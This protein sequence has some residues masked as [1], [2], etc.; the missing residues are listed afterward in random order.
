MLDRV[1]NKGQDL[2]SL[3][4]VCESQLAYGA[5]EENR[6]V[7]GKGAWHTEMGHHLA[8][9]LCCCYQ[10]DPA[11][12]S[13]THQRGGICPSPWGSPPS[14]VA[15][16]FPAQYTEEVAQ[17]TE[18]SIMGGE[19]TL[20]ALHNDRAL[21]HISPAAC[22]PGAHPS[23]SSKLKRWVSAGRDRSITLF[24]DDKKLCGRKWHNLKWCFKPAQY[25][26]RESR[27]YINKTMD[28]SSA[29]AD[30]ILHMWGEKSLL[31]PYSCK[32]HVIFM[33][34]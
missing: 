2:W 4:E 5:Q 20:S 32:I 15:R 26:W 17:H 22:P 18:G 16:V 31:F 29:Q 10:Q 33:P 3:T 13:Q 14:Q 25:T 28:I 24:L 21:R 9:L 23:P 11:K 12:D 30:F 27:Q 34:Y 6:T 1:L 19:I 7:P 8:W